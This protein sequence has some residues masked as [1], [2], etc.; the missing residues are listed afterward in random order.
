MNFMFEWQK[1]YVVAYFLVKNS[2]LYNK[3]FIN[4]T[5]YDA[6]RIAQQRFQQK[7]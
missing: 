3:K 2:R 7:S 6:N 5:Q 1:Q 4:Y